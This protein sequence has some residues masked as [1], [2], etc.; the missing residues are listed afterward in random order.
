M[1][2]WFIELGFLWQLGLLYLVVINLITFFA[3]GIDKLKAQ[4]QRR[5]VRE[6]MLWCLALIG[7]SPGALAGM[8]FFRHKTKKVSFQLGIV[9]ILAVQA[10]LIFILFSQ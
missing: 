4:V 9:L 3:Y 5:R 7:G 2:T 10:G 8:H 1:M 6:T